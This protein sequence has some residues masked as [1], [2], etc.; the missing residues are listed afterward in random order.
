M[1]PSCLRL[2]KPGGGAET[3]S[4]ELL[5]ARTDEQRSHGGAPEQEKSDMSPCCSAAVYKEGMVHCVPLA[6]W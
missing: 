6:A 4:G 2:R 5:E 3:R 1:R